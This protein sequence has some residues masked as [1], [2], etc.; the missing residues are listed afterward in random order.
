MLSPY[1]PHTKVIDVVL[2]ASSKGASSTI[3]TRS[4]SDNNSGWGK[5]KS[6]PQRVEFEGKKR[7]LEHE[8]KQKAQKEELDDVEAQN[9]ES[10][11]D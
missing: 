7:V 6:A 10:D 5:V 8:A 3:T 11:S 1:L 4:T 2:G 9:S